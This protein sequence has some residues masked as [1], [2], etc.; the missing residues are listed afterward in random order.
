MSAEIN[1]DQ[2]IAEIR[3]EISI[4]SRVYPSM[5]IKGKLRKSAADYQID[6]MTAALET[7]RRVQA[8]F[9]NQ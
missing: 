3:R 8:G 7:L 5:I 2:Q 9:F 6:C 4:R 1:L